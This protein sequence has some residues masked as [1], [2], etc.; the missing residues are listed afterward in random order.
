MILIINTCK[1]KLSELEFVRPIEKIVKTNFVTKHC[2]QITRKDISAADKIIICGTAL[3]DFEYLKQ[4]FSW[5]KTTDKP[6]LGICAG[7]QIISQ[8]LGIPLKDS[9]NIGVRK[10][11]TTTKNKL[12]E[13]TFDAYFLHTKTAI[14]KFVILAT[15]NDVSCVV[16]H[17]DKEIYGCIFHLEV[18]NSGIITNFSKRQKL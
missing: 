15:T 14:E 8:A 17:P 3:A 13:G 6:V 1:E 4:D 5:I 9:T 2:A 11:I 7:M 12:C 18:M 16:K 10:V